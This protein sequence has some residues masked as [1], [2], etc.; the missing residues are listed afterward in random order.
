[1]NDGAMLPQIEE[2]VAKIEAGMQCKLPQ[3]EVDY[4]RSIRT[5]RDVRL[6]MPLD[7]GSGRFKATAYC[8]AVAMGAHPYVA[9]HIAD[10][11][12]FEWC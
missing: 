3:D 8:A 9:Y 12:P 10:D 1:M 4:L 6:L 2:V 11:P 5:L 7:D